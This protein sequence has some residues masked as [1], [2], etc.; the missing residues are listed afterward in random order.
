MRRLAERVYV[1]CTLVYFS[2]P[3]APRYHAIGESPDDPTTQSNLPLFALQAIVYAIALGYI[4]KWWPVFRNGLRQG[5]WVLVLASLAIA[6][7]GWSEVPTFTARRAIVVFST[8]MFGIYFGATFR[9]EVQVRLLCWAFAIMAVSSV[10]AAVLFPDYGVD[11]LFHE[12]DWQGVYAQKNILGRLMLL[13]ALVFVLRPGRGVWSSAARL[14][15]VLLCVIVLFFSG[16]RTSFVVL[17]ALLVAIPVYRVA[18]ARRAEV[19]VPLL[20]VALLVVVGGMM[21]LPDNYG[22]L[23]GML[24][25]DETLT[26]RTFLWAGAV[27]AISAKPWLGYGYSAFWLGTT[28]PSRSIITDVGWG[29]TQAHNGYLDLCLDLGVVGLSLFVWSMWCG[30]LTA[31]KEYRPALRASLWPFV[32]VSMTVIINVVEGDLFKG[33]GLS[34]ALYV[35]ALVGTDIVAGEARGTESPRVPARSPGRASRPAIRP[36]GAAPIA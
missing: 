13:G 19:G 7:A 15:G 34:W 29:V 33:N 23:L 17:L 26:G 31:I 30:F 28:G 6:S 27:E 12:G 22:A 1:V 18:V 14:G 32:V 10:V 11:R 36:R 5:K 9:R 4:A 3:F 2:A 25:R 20:M 21:W 16:S 35:S 24:G 8:T